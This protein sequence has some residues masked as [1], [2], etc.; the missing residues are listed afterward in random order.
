MYIDNNQAL[1]IPYSAFPEENEKN[2]FITFVEEQFALTKPSS[3]RAKGA[4]R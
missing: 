3:G 1:L 4:R 2:K